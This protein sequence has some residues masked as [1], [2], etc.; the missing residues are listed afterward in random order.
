MLI[1]TKFL[2]LLI[3][4]QL[5]IT[6]AGIY[7]LFN[8]SEKIL[9]DEFAQRI[10]SLASIMAVSLPLFVENTTDQELLSYL[11]KQVSEQSL[12]YLQLSRPD[13]P[14]IK[15]GDCQSCE[16]SLGSLN[17]SLSSH[18]MYFSFSEATVIK[19]PGNK[20]SQETQKNVKL[21][22]QNQE[23]WNL[24]LGASFRKLHNVATDS[25]KAL[26]ILGLFQILVVALFGY[27]F[28]RVIRKKIQPIQAACHK[29]VSGNYNVQLDTFENDETFEVIRAFNLMSSELKSSLVRIEEQRAQMMYSS[30][31]Q[32]LGEMAGGVAHEINNPLTVIS[33]STYFLKL[34]YLP[35]I[36]EEKR[37]AALETVD[38]IE[39]M[40]TRITAIVKGLRR[41]SRSGESD[42]VNSVLVSSLVIDTLSLCQEKFKNNGIELVVSEFEDLSVNMREIQ[43][44]QVL[45]NLLNN[46]FDALEKTKSP[47][48]C[49]NVNFDNDWL[50]IRIQDNGPGIP[51]EIKNKILE[52]F[53]T[54]KEVGKGTGIGLSISIGI[55]RDHHGDLI[56]ESLGSP[57][58][59]LVKLPRT[60]TK[61]QAIKKAA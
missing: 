61:S 23:T 34:R 33:G 45:V 10:D 43:I 32:A 36:P 27:F 26:L 46:A 38:K 14:D 31:M 42:P 15:I 24:T 13:K 11:N 20:L 12:N 4:S 55:I 30:K 2:L 40:V 17:Q 57:T 37:A 50:Y 47:K 7:I 22:A 44:S 60:N 16:T 19:T 41:F 3:G 58:I 8:F 25:F 5:S 28:S 6:L 56:V 49:L 59:F 48:I 29:I 35:A 52:P 39:K 18:S 51:E 54:T 53:F 1:R 9:R 21:S